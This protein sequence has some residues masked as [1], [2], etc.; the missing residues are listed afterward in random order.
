V[1]CEMT[2]KQN[3][4]R[5][6]AQRFVHA[7]YRGMLRREPDPAA[8]E[9]YVDAILHGQGHAAVAEAFLNC[10]EFKTNN[11]VK[12]FVPPGHFYSPI[13]DPIEIERYL[14]S[15][16]SGLVPDHLPGISLDRAEMI[17]TWKNLL[18]FLETIPFSGPKVAQFRYHFENPAYSWGDGSILHAMLR[19]YRPKRLIEIG[20]GWSSAC[21]VDTI[22]NYLESACDV[23]FVDPFPELLR[24]VIGDSKLNFRVLEIPIQQVPQAVFDILD[25]GDML[26]V[27]ST[28]VLR[29][30]SDVCFE[31]FDILPRLARGV[32]V[33]FHDIFWPFE[34]PRQWLIEEN[35]SWNEI[36]AVRAFLSHN[37]AWR[38]T[39]F[40]DYMAK[41]EAH[42]IESTYP[43]FMLNSGGALWLQRS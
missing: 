2:N 21:I 29:T 3:S 10:E 1:K 14:K 8:A 43:Q 22:E 7:L 41:C 18:P 23:T 30:G 17:C 6:E 25:S 34:Y 24:A 15:K 36:Y 42:M 31:L 12:L 26:F 27:D 5:E 33:H 32:L 16:Y 35:R 9:Y 28:H 11:S 4:D 19:L 37:D 39:F 40:N 38:I 13:T 20:S